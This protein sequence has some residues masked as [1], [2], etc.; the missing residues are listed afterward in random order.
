[1]QQNLLGLVIIRSD[2]GLLVGVGFL[3]VLTV[4]ELASG[5]LVGSHWNVWGTR[6]DRPALYW[7]MVALKVAFILFVAYIFLLP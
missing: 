7:S 1:M 2:G 3:T 5:N 4:Y 6:K